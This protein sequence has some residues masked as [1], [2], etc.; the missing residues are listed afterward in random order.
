MSS[1]QPGG[2]TT[3]IIAPGFDDR[4]HNAQ[5]TFRSILTAMAE[6]GNPVRIDAE[7]PAL[8]CS[9]ASLACLLTLA[10]FDTP[11][12]LSPSIQSDVYTYLRFHAGAPI[13]PEPGAAAFVLLST[14]DALPDLSSFNAGT[15]VSPETAA[16][17]L[18]DVEDFDSGITVSL[19]GPGLA[20]PKTFS[21]AGVT[22][23]RWRQRQ[24]LHD[25]FP[26]GVD[27]LFCHGKQIV[28]LPRS[29]AIT[30]STVSESPSVFNHDQ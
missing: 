27:F 28:G 16:T 20:H 23:A 10:D 13:S 3:P 15:A 8:G 9:S 18:V 17:I 2:T 21:P 11:V 24:E 6:P 22:H 4:V 25:L 26:L 7:L 12:W 1:K 30:F 14:A 5:Q 29:T 19:S